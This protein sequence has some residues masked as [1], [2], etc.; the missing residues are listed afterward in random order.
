M[1]FGS[2]AASQ[3]EPAG[4]L[5]QCV[6]FLLATPRTLTRA[7]AVPF[8]AP[9]GRRRAR[10][11]A[12]LA[13]EARA[14]PALA[15]EV[16]DDG[17][18][19]LQTRA[20]APVLASQLSPSPSL[21]PCNLAFRSLLLVC[22]VALTKSESDSR[23]RP[24][25]VRPSQTASS[26]RRSRPEPIVQSRFP[27]TKKGCELAALSW[28]ELLQ[29]REAVEVRAL[30]RSDRL[31]RCALVLASFCCPLGVPPVLLASV[32]ARTS[33]ALLLSASSASSRSIRGPAGC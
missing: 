2:K 16:I 29:A 18:P 21:V 31:L 23:A 33:V 7:D 10:R 6:P 13:C 22:A 28:N 20:H 30:D 4:P 26:R 11:A 24:S 12:S 25:Q 27:Q 1:G 8:L 32:D 15:R 19:A 3:A 5:R 9:V 17:P 14:R